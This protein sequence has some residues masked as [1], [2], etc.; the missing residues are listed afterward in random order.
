[1]YVVRHISSSPEETSFDEDS[2]LF[3]KKGNP[4]GNTLVVVQ[5]QAYARVTQASVER[6]PWETSGVL[7]GAAHSTADG[8]ELVII[9]D[10]VP[11]SLVALGKG[12]AP[13]AEEWK[14]LKARL[15]DPD[16]TDLHI[17]GW[18]YCDPGIGLFQ[19]RTDVTTIQ[20]A[21]APDSLL[22][23][24]NPSSEDGAFYVSKGDD[25]APTGGYY[26]ELP[27][28]GAES[29][30]KWSGDIK[31]ALEWLRQYVT[32]SQDNTAAGPGALSYGVTTAS[33]LPSSLL[34]TEVLPT[35]APTAPLDRWAMSSMVAVSDE[36]D[37]MR[38][39]AAPAL[40]KERKTSWRMILIGTIA[41]VAI[42]I[43]AGL[44]ASPFGSSQDGSD[45]QIAPQVSQTITPVG[46]TGSPGGSIPSGG[47]TGQ[48]ASATPP[49]SGAVLPPASPTRDATATTAATSTPTSTHTTVP[50]GTPTPVPPSPTATSTLTPVPPTATST[51]VPPSPTF[52]RVPPRPTIAPPTPTRPTVIY[53]TV[54]P[55]DSLFVIAQRYGTT[56]DAIRAANNLPGTAIYSGQV[57]VI[58]LRR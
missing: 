53:Y 37:V 28:V 18:F 49:G 2:G 42:V 44:G 41:L 23:L 14:S 20:Q 24:V 38:P 40:P 19:P 30:L 8:R 47:S 21:F 15:A 10:A 26:E 46:S 4:A 3:L 32:A 34:S 39:P 50:T 43:T 16:N 25:L 58:P 54:R 13:N 1:M 29:V 7:L 56:I 6:M 33:E 5:R 31:G 48:L 11:L 57:L 36:P 55:G 27:A 9:S 35:T 12:A 22:L 51:P 17:V 52:T 45:K